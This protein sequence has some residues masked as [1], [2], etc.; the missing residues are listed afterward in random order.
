[1][2]KAKQQRPDPALRA[3]VGRS[4][5]G[6][7]QGR[8]RM[9]LAGI[10]IAGAGLAAIGLA[11]CAGGAAAHGDPGGTWI[12][13]LQT[14]SGTCPDG[15]DSDLDVSGRG[16]VF[17]PGDGVIALRGRADKADPTDLRA[18]HAG[19]TIDHKPY[20][21]VFEARFTPD[22]N[23]G[24][25]AGTYGTPECRATIRLHRPTHTALQRLLGN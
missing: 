11:A 19:A 17:V 20:P 24:A 15:E 25:V 12:G 10:G 5:T 9:A 4:G 14:V 21:M 2:T 23:G 18:Q 1:M 3:G 16:V 6:L 7:E 13:R 8:K 22:A